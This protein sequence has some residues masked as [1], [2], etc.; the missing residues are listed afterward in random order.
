MAKGINIKGQDISTSQKG[1]V[2]IRSPKLATALVQNGEKTIEELRL[3][4]GN[5]S[6]SQ[7]E[8]DDAGRVVIKNA[9]AAKA[10]REK[11]KDFGA[12]AADSNGICGVRC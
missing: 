7:V 2:V 12:S 10:I 3:E 1:Q 9:A 5:I 11:I 6:L 8:I 4:I